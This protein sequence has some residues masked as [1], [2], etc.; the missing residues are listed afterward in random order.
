MF[1]ALFDLHAQYPILSPF[2][3]SLGAVPSFIGL[4]MGMYSITHIPGNILAGF[5]ID[6]YGSKI[7]II[8]SL[9][10]AG[11]LLLIQS[12]VTNPWELLAIRSISGF[13]LAFLS[14]ACLA[15]LAK[16]GKNEVQ[17]GNLMAGNG[18]VQTMA[19]ILSPAAGAIL[20]AEIGFT[21][22]FTLLGWVLVTTSILALFGIRENRENMQ[23]ARDDATAKQLPAANSL[24]G[25]DHTPWLFYSLP[26]A[27][28]C[29]QGILFFELPL[30]PLSQQSIFT[31]GLLF[32]VISLGGLLTLSLM[33]LNRY[34]PFIRTAVGASGLAF[35]FYILA[36]K[37]SVPIYVPLFLVG[38][39]KGIIFPAM[40]TMLSS[41]T[42]AS[43]YGRIFAYL[44]ISFSLGAFFG[45]LL[46]GH[47]R[48]HISPF[49]IA[50]LVLMLALSLLPRH[51]PV[52]RHR[53]AFPGK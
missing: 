38:M 31:S 35:A 28:S 34:S 27:V 22:T 51:R 13:I 47:I 25:R 41:M 5:G 43:R 39:F 49:F 11:I 23:P 24:P 19:S 14:P 18:I 4:I 29:S 17:Q 37:W 42:N 52:L 3:L 48:D 32:S 8:F 21:A 36:V 9:F 12:K 40:A 46:A 33:F 7:F 10:I 50:F 26:F 20:V 44:S 2:A 6:R 15:F 16:L 45:P 53:T 1:I 30:N